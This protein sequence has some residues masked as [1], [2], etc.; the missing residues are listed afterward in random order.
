MGRGTTISQCQS[1][2]QSINQ[3]VSQS[4]TT[5]LIDSGAGPRGTDDLTGATDK[6]TEVH[7]GEQGLVLLQTRPILS[8]E[9]VRV[10]SETM[11]LSLAK[12]D[13]AWSNGGKR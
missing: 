6:C 1:I 9:R 12:V 3:P 8:H 7:S 4:L 13:L 2:N 5:D 10:T 11:S